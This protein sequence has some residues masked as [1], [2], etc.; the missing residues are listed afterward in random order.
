LN[1]ARRLKH[2][3]LSHGE[4]DRVRGDA[5]GHGGMSQGSSLKLAR[6]RLRGDDAADRSKFMTLGIT[7]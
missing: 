5:L 7:Q 6:M 4:R 3:S 1:K 2:R